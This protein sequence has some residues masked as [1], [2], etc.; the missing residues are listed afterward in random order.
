VTASAE[1]VICGAGVA[2]ATL[3]Y[4]LARSGMRVTVVERHRV[5]YGASGTAAG[6]LM[7]AAPADADT[8][9]GRLIARGLAEHR[10]LAEAL[11]GHERYDYR[12]MPSLAVARDE[13]EASELRRLWGD[14]CV[15]AGGDARTPWIDGPVTAVVDV[16][17]AAQIDPAR[18]TA[19]LLDE[20]IALGANFELADVQGLRRERG[21]VTGVVTS[22]GTIATPR[23]VVAMG[24][25]SMEAERWL[26][27]PLPMIP[28]KGQI[29]RYRMD[30][31]PEGGFSTLE[32]N[33]AVKK[34][35]GIVCSG[36]TE[37]EAGFDLGPTA[38]ARA[39][40]EAWARRLS[41]LFAGQE[42]IE[43][44]ACLR[45]LSADGLPIV[46]ALDEPDGAF[47]ATGHGR[48]GIALSPATGK[49]LAEV[50]TTGNSPSLDLVP[51]S[52][53]RFRATPPSA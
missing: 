52:P 36:T 51:F 1:A 34:P 30:D 48:K 21:R 15:R 27:T 20:A 5:A 40:I 6:L 46:G 9:L 37:E 13:D 7:P 47:V 10:S 3:A 33:Y 35:T 17:G 18:F 2:G 53:T 16:P 26:K 24:P 39:G 19:V 41:G 4:Y 22:A 31:A 38:E 11:G 14:A 43:Q 45:P 28:L 12:E 49:A 32:G 25:W 50:I 23:V 42:P 29:L 44:T 8:T